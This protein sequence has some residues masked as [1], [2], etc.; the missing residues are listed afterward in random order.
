MTTTETVHVVTAFLRHQGRVLVLQRSG[1]VGSYRGRWAAVSGYLEEPT[2]LAQALRE[3]D[4]ETGLAA[5]DLSLV[6]EGAP[7][8][9]DDPALERRWVVHPFLFDIASLPSI[10]LDWEHSAYRWVLPVGLAELQT[11]PSLARAL[12]ACW[13]GVFS[14]RAQDPVE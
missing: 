6:A 12:E 1:R 7:F 3:I 14:G 8:A 10:R 4:E 2:A 11:V 13:P 5:A 9:V